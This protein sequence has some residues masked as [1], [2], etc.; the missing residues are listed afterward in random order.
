LV[1][2]LSFVEEALAKLNLDFDEGLQVVL[3]WTHLEPGLF[4]CLA[5]VNAGV[6]I[7]LVV[8]GKPAW[9]AA[10][11]FC[12]RD[13]ALPTTRAATTRAASI[14]EVRPEERLYF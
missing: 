13:R 3:P 14:I 12:R 5:V 7:A 9:S 11:G 8:K 4:F 10:Y 1:P 6:Q 2:G